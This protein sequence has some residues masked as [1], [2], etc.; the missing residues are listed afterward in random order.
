MSIRSTTPIGLPSEGE[1]DDA[2]GRAIARI[3]VLRINTRDL[4]APR[5]RLKH[6]FLYMSLL[7]AVVAKATPD[8]GAQLTRSLGKPMVVDE[9]KQAKL[10]NKWQGVKGEWKSVDGAI[11]GRE[12]KADKHAAVLN[13][14]EPNHNSAIQFSF[15]LD[16]AKGFNLSFNKKR[17]HLFR[18]IVTADGV[19]VNLDKDKQDPKSKPKRLANTKGRFAQGKWYSMLV[20]VEGEN[21]SVLT[22]NGV[23][24]TA[25]H[26]AIDQ[27]KPNYRF[28]MRGGDLLLDDLKI[29][30]LK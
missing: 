9:I 19:A 25:K 27:A 24:L 28:V 16:G 6:L 1:R 14:R 18:V 13:F 23:K 10:G 12:L 4:T 26:A 5:M 8:K 17:G 3:R 20:T 2:H 7:F 21:V 30:K 22:D 15:K 29:W 11:V